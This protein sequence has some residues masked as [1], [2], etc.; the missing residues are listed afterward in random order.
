[1]TTLSVRHE[2]SI[3]SDLLCSYFHPGFENEGN[4]SHGVFN[5]YKENAKI[6]LLG[7]RHKRSLD[8]KL[9]A[10]MIMATAVHLQYAKFFDFDHR[11]ESE[12]AGS[13]KKPAKRVS[14]T[15]WLFLTQQ[16]KIRSMCI[17]P[18]LVI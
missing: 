7:D 12:D 16:V 5:D 8:K 15:V 10:E 17:Q 1:M 11:F 14:F 9:V 4:G 18:S 3:V 13:A 6:G 2:H